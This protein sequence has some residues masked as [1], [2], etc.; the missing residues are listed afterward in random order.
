MQK[1]DTDGDGKISDE[2]MA[3]GLKDQGI[4]PRD[5]KKMMKDLD[6]DGDGKVSSD[7]MYAATGPPDEFA[8]SPGEPGYEAP[9]E[10]EETPVSLEEFKN[11]LGQ[12][13]KS[14]QDAWDKIV[15]PAKNEMTPEQFE[16]QAK[17]LG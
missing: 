9:K 7:E 8:K 6:K 11:R 5:A 12:A 1:M 10:P 13:Y 15:D 16:K 3:K 14:G 2:E 17:D 4:S